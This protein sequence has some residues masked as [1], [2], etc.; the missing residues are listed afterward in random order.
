MNI[1][2][3]PPISAPVDI[4]K[5]TEQF[6]QLRDK[7]KEIQTKH[8]D[9]LKPY[10]E[11]L[12]QLNA[13]ILAHLQNQGAQNMK[14]SGGHSIYVTEKKSAS[15]EDMSAFWAWVVTSGNFDMVD[16]KANV[17]AVFDHIQEH[18]CPPPG[19][20]V[21]TSHVAGVRRGSSN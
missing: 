10:V 17:T 21:S 1:P 14:T 18:K 8:K 12:E 5:R 9:E 15:I 11:T 6:I 4:N 13:D 20:N 7:I 16:K 19:V 3:T 2:V